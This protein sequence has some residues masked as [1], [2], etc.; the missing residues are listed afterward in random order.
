[1]FDL[2]NVVECDDE[3]KNFESIVIEKG[4]ILYD[5]LKEILKT[6]GFIFPLE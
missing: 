5:K 4:P 3:I 1:M 2:F 6:D